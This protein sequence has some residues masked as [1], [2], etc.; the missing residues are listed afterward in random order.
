MTGQK[1]TSAEREPSATPVAGP[2]LVIY[3]CGGHGREMV[4][5]S[6]AMRRSIVFLDDHG[7]PDYGDVEPTTFADLRDTDEIIIAAGSPAT[8]RKMAAK[9]ERWRF[10]TV[11]AP[12]AVV[13]PT[14]ELGMGA[15]I[16]DFSYIGSRVTVG[17]HFQCNV[18]S[19][20]H[21]DCVIGDFVTFSPGTL[22]LGTVHVDDDVFV[23]AGAMIRNGSPERPLRI[24]R[25]ATIGMGAVVTKDVLDGEVVV[26]NPAQPMAAKSL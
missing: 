13:D 19:H 26:G 8:R 23:G 6:R 25:G 7:A 20:V 21:H 14:A 1:L 4:L 12:C 24:G 9:V 2:R 5:A 10:A 11:V 3:G 16:C 17:R 18:R 22:C 15:Q